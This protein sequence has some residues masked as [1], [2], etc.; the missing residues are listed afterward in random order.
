MLRRHVARFVAAVDSQSGDDEDRA[1]AASTRQMKET[2]SIASR[3]KM[4]DIQEYFLLNVEKPVRET[5][6]V[7]ALIDGKA[8]IV[9]DILMD[10]D[11]LVEIFDRFLNG[12]LEYLAFDD[13]PKRVVGISAAAPRSGLHVQIKAIS[14]TQQDQDAGR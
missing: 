1:R 3:G 7:S 4:P 13:H 11:A 8:G 2:K 14:L 9:G 6:K 5:V 12:N 10:S